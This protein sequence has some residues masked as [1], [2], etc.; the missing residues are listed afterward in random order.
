MTDETFAALVKV[1]LPLCAPPRAYVSVANDPPSMTRPA[2]VE[3]PVN[4][5][6]PAGTG[7]LLMSNVKTLFT[8]GEFDL[9]EPVMLANGTLTV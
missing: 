7:L 9:A 4:C 3:L 1:T 8:A 6:P 5:N 2:P